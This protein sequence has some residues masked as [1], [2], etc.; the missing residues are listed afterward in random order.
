L[1]IHTPGKLGKGLTPQKQESRV[2]GQTNFRSFNIT[3]T[4]DLSRS[5]AY[6]Q[7]VSCATF[8]SSSFVPL[9]RQQA[10]RRQN[11]Q[12]LKRFNLNNLLVSL[13]QW[14]TEKDHSVQKYRFSIYFS[15]LKKKSDINYW[16]QNKMSSIRN[17]REVSPV[18][19]EVRLS[20]KSNFT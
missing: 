2:S 11:K 19:F 7:L 4:S 15:Y 14:F 18:K 5:L 16:S 13:M 6:Q 3:I 9:N 20:Y 1:W 17:M 8:D 10:F 12:C